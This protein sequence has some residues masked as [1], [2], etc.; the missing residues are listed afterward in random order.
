M[1]GPKIKTDRREAAQAM[2]RA[3]KSY[4]VISDTLTMSIGT[5]HTI[6]REAS[7]AD[8][9]RMVAELKRGSIARHLMLADFLMDELA[10]AVKE[11]TSVKDLA[12]AAAIMTDKAVML[13]KL[14]EKQL[15][16]RNLALQIGTIV[17]D[18][19]AEPLPKEL[20]QLRETVR[21]PDLE[22]TRQIVKEGMELVR[23]QERAKIKTEH[24][25]VNPVYW[26]HAIACF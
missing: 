16:A 5:V 11:T 6:A 12:I 1:G 20:D 9:T 8:L 25:G 10:D 2:L 18:D 4:R 3:G 22:E 19:E 7:E 21:L 23:A 26:T 24:Y 14:Q 15:K 17:P 13:E